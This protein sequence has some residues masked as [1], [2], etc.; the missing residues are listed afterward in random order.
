VVDFRGAEM[1]APAIGLRMKIQKILLR[2]LLCL[3]AASTPASAAAKGWILDLDK[4]SGVV[5]MDAVG[6]P[7]M[8]RIHGKG[9][10]PKGQLKLEDKK[11]N[12]AATFKIDSMDTGIGMRN[13]HMKEK[14]L[15]IGKYPD[16]KLTF[17]DMAL[18]ANSASENFSAD[19]LPFKGLLSLH[20]VENPVEGT[21]KV[22]RKSDQ[23]TIDARFSFKP[24]AYKVAS[25]S[26][27]GVTMADDVNVTVQI[28]AP[29][30]A[31]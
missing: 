18:P 3:F 22:D 19:S 28:A 27:A 21:A 6:K 5:L 31:E 14:Y 9:D 23:T 13:K 10:A 25:P 7:S 26:F 4:G 17:K 15:E 29:M 24:S 1:S 16:A 20:G 8:L 11:L 30:R 12:G 2:A